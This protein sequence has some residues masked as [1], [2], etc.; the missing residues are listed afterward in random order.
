MADIFNDLYK[1]PAENITVYD[2]DSLRADIDEGDYRWEKQRPLRLYGVDTP[3]LAPR[4]S[5]YEDADGVRDTAGRDSE[6][7][8]AIEARDRVVA[9]L[10]AA[11]PPVVVQTVKIPGKPLRDKYG[12]TLARVF[13]SVGSVVFD[14]AER[15][16]TEKHAKPYSGGSKG[17]WTALRPLGQEDPSP[18]EIAKEITEVIDQ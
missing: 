1:R 17:L 5:N 13:V 9:Y 2:G 15:L 16:L 6:K 10:E 3:E 4:W 7:Q 14:L 12:R 11:M 8:A 18:H